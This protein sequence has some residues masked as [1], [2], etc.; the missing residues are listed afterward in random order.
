MGSGKRQCGD[1]NRALAHPLRVRILQAL[2]REAAGNE[3]LSALTGEALA[4]VDYHLR[5]LRDCSCIDVVETQ[6]EA[7]AGGSIFQARP[8]VASSLRSWEQVPGPLREEIA[9][10]F[11]QG[12]SGV[13]V[14]GLEK[15][16]QHREGP[17]VIRLELV[18]DERGW[19]ELRDIFNDPEG[20]IQSVAARSEERLR[21]GDGAALQVLAAALQAG[22][23]EKGREE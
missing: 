20:P 2:T 23:A 17:G 5:V 10:A 14:S 9:A 16:G 1:F 18:V 15:G 8:E 6:A 11:L 21:A 4:K 13:V 3:Q 12:L 7:S 19:G 22:R